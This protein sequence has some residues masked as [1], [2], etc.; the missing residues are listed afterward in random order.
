AQ[1]GGPIALVQDGDRIV[2]DAEANRINWDVDPGEAERRRSSWVAP[3]LP[4]ERGVLLRYVRSV[5]SASL[6]CVTD[7]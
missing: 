3:P 2:I 1:E 4:A 7:A 6:G 5:S